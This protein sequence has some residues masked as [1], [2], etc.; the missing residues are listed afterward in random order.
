MNNLDLNFIF[1]KMILICYFSGFGLAES[2]AHF[3]F[4]PNGGHLQPGCPDMGQAILNF[5][6]HP[7][8]GKNSFYKYITHIRSTFI[9]DVS[10][11]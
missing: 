3:D 6:G 2:I 10:Y 11:M 5:L 7:T 8:F 4:Y 1:N 9:R